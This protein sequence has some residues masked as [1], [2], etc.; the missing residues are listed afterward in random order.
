MKTP[1]RNTIVIA[2]TVIIVGNV[3][4]AGRYDGLIDVFRNATRGS[5]V[6]SVPRAEPPTQLTRQIDDIRQHNQ[7]VH[8]WEAVNPDGSLRRYDWEARGIQNPQELREHITDVR[9]NPDDWR[10]LDPDRFAYGQLD[11]G[12]SYQGTVV[13]DNLTSSN[14]GT[15]FIN[16]N[17]FNRISSLGGRQ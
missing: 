3:A 8:A 4:F 7:A 6:P 17:I 16:P 13:I 11:P 1:T 15:A 12:H 10:Q 2:L 5:E 9:N 14:G